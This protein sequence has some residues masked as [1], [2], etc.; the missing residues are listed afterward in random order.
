MHLDKRPYKSI[1]KSEQ[2]ENLID[3]KTNTLSSIIYLFI[4][5]IQNVKGFEEVIN[6]YREEETFPY[7]LQEAIVIYCQVNWLQN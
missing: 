7:L 1:R 4:D 5:E 2:L 6:A 3:E